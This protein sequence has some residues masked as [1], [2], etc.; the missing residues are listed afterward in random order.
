MGTSGSAAAT[1]IAS[2]SFHK[3]ELPNSLL[4]SGSNS[5]PQTPRGDRKPRE[6]TTATFVA[7]FFADS[8]RTSGLLEGLY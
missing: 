8:L 4:Q 5:A 2:S 1:S 3:M 6:S 7:I